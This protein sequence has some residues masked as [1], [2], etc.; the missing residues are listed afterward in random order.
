MSTVDPLIPTA[1]RAQNDTFTTAAG[2]E[3]KI[4]LVL[5]GSF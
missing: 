2:W 5:N 4:K 1:L 3:F